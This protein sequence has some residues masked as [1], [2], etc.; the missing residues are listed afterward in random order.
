MYVKINNIT[1]HLMINVI[2]ADKFNDCRVTDKFN[3]PKPQQR[4]I[5]K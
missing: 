5:N 3:E 1:K 2:L 4:Q